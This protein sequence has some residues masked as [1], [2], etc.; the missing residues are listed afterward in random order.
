MKKDILVVL[1]GGVDS[2]TL[3]YDYAPRTALA[4]SFDYG[5]NHNAREIDCARHHCKLLGIEHIVIPLDFIGRYFS[6]SLLSGADAIPAGD[7]NDSNM[8]STVVPFRNGIML[9]VAAGLAE[10]RGLQR[11][12]IANHGGDHHI[13]PDCRPTFIKAM[14]EAAQKGTYPGIRVEGPYTYLTKAQIIERGHRLGVDY[15]NTYSCYKGGA[16]HCGECG[17]CRERRQ[18]FTDAGVPDPTLYDNDA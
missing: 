18:A 4:V 9:A 3:L 13:Y 2:V 5:S 14:D 11:V 1:S 6:S 17:T 8:S 16:H 15:S 12:M 7:Y 10:S